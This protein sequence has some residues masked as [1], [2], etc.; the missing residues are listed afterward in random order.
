MCFSVLSDRAAKCGVT[1]KFRFCGLSALG[2]LVRQIVPCGTVALFAGERHRDRL[3]RLRAALSGFA[4]RELLLGEAPTSALFSMPD[5]IR[6]SVGVG[7]R[8]IRAARL[9]ASVCGGY[10]VAVPALPLARG[11]FEPTVP[12]VGGMLPARCADLVLFDD[13]FV[14]TGGRAETALS[15]LCAEEIVQDGV[16]AGRE[17]PLDFSAAADLLGEVPANA[18][19]AKQ[20]AASALYCMEHRGAP[21]FAGEE[22][23]RILRENTGKSEAACALGM[24]AY[25]AARSE[26]LFAAVPRAYFV[27]DYAARV[28]RAAPRG[29]GAARLLDMLSVPDAQTAFARAEVFAQVQKKFALRARLLSEYAARTLLRCVQEGERVPRFAARDLLEAYDTAAEL[30]PLLSAPALEREFGLLPNPEA[31]LAFG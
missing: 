13:G 12:A 3:P 21:P 30:S 22:A 7:A 14:G 10:A 26:A 16:F 17:R 31:N 18:E 24:L 6:V 5:G 1:T 2:A 11:M 28:A 8:G 25:F 29:G 4:V 9:F 15:A 19:R 23:A 20:F 27:P